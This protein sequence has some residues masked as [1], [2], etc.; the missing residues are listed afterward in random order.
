[1][2]FDGQFAVHIGE[3]D[4]IDG[5]RRPVAHPDQA[6]PFDVR[7]FAGI[8]AVAEDAHGRVEALRLAGNQGNLRDRP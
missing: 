8:D 4:V 6:V 7:M 1:M 5:E 2:H 3:G